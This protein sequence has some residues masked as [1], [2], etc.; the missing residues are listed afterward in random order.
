MTEV[1]PSFDMTALAPPPAPLPTSRNA[2]PSRSPSN[3]RSPPGSLAT[4]GQHL[5]KERR[6]DTEK[7]Q[8]LSE[9]L[10]D[11]ERRAQQHLERCGEE[12]GRKMEEQKRKEKQ[13][14]SAAEEKRRQQQQAEK[15]VRDSACTF[16][17]PPQC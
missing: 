2:S 5:A 11:K 6:K 16:S 13:R 12:R 9:L 1:A 14:R 10:R 7:T 4:D 17:E 8:E 15:F 3:H